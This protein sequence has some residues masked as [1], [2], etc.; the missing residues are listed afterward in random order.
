MKNLITI[1]LA[2]TIYLHGNNIKIAYNQSYLQKNIQTA[3]KE[4]EKENIELFPFYNSGIYNQ[5]GLLVGL[6]KGYIQLAVV[7]KKFLEEIVLGELTEKN[8]ENINFV[9]VAKNE[10]LYVIARKQ[11]FSDLAQDK[12]SKIAYILNKYLNKKDSK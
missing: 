5:N 10:E 12:K 6:I 11:Y 1:L 8:L 7:E 4:L 2:F 3:V 9:T